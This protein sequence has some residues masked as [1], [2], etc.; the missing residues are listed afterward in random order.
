MEKFLHFFI[1]LPFA[2]FLA[3]LLLPRRN[4]KLISGFAI[5]I[6]GIQLLLIAA[7]TFQWLLNQHPVLDIKHI[8]LFKTEGFEF[9]IDFYF[10]RITAV[11]AMVGCLLT[12]AVAI[13]SKYYIHREE[14]FKRY[15]STLLLFSLG[16]NF[17]I[18]SGNFETLFIGW[19][20]L[21]ITSFLLIAFYRDRFL[22]VKNSLKTIFIYRIGDICLILAMWMAHHVWQANITFK[23]LNDPGVAGFLAQNEFEV[24]FIA[25]MIFIAATLK[26]GQ[27]PFS[28]WVP[29]AMEGPTTSSAIFYGALAIHAGV[30]LMMRTFPL[31][32]NLPVI[33][34]LMIATGLATFFV[35]INIAR[36]QPSVKTQI[37]YLSA[38]QIGLMFIEV[39]LGFHTLALIHFAGN[40]FLRTWQLLIS[41]SV[42]SY[43]IHDMFFSFMPSKPTTQTGF[44]SKIRNSFYLLGVKEWNLDFSIYR[45]LWDPFKWLGKQFGFM[46][47]KVSLVLLAVL[48]F[49]G[50][51]LLAAP[52]NLPVQITHA[53][54]VV[55]IAIALILI[56]IA[57]AE[58]GDARKAWVLI[59]AGHHFILLS[60]ALNESVE[61]RQLLW[62]LSG[63]LA[64]G[65]TG[66]FALNRIYAIDKDI[67]LD[68][69]HGYVYEKPV[70]G[71]IF[72]L[73]A[74]ALV[75]LPL[76]PTFI[77]IDV[78]LTHIHEGQTALIILTACCFLFLEISILRIYARVF[79][80]Q[81]KKKNHPM[82]Y[83][84]S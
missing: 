75:G 12:F 11:Y 62:Y 47:A 13:F 69:F 84:N 64:A 67:R 5:I 54:P 78:L 46:T 44:F 28:S 10:D 2:G 42:M 29:R 77:G 61:L 53:L 49:S 74:L 48:Y 81:H 63:T 82:A 17:L 20:I 14:G 19:E 30:F 31:W 22:P 41:P 65:I 40:A 68:K 6:S 8:V 32:E 27:L 39:A 38:A 15:F 58:K 55:F 71:F 43:F 36:V 34:V 23:Q 52:G 66:Y 59:F 83:K 70:A 18:F 56:L 3:S 9:F 24:L 73:A 45:S 16:Y 1:V 60:I 72:L 26:S 57:F 4:E 51:N 80:G 25:V 76:T 37:A 33:R 35:A 7:F 21:G 50:L 79:M